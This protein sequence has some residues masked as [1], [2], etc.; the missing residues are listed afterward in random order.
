MVINGSRMNL[1][2]IGR[3]NK[4]QKVFER[5]GEFGRHRIIGRRRQVTCDAHFTGDKG[6]LYRQTFHFMFYVV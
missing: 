1:G 2:F 5:W 3:I 4:T 6:S